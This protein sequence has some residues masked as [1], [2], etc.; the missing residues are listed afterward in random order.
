MH[1]HA[2][3]YYLFFSGD[4]CCGPHAHHAVLVARARHA[5]GPFE[6]AAA[7][8]SNP[9][10]ALLAANAHWQAPDHNCVVT[11]AAGQDWLAYPY[12]AIDP[13]QPTFAAIDESEGNSRRVL[14][15]DKL[16]YADGWP[17]L[18]PDAPSRQLQ[19]AP[20]VQ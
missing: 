7:A 8:S 12:H 14:L 11:D 9:H 2:G 6:T 15:L 10:T 19:S 3:W 4:N 1:Q 18:A 20:A 17:V 5:T 13:R 16:D